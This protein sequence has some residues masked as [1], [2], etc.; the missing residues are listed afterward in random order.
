M[1]RNRFPLITNQPIGKRTNIK[2]VCQSANAWMTN[3]RQV[4]EDRGGSEELAVILPLAENPWTAVLRPS[5]SWGSYFCIISVSGLRPPGVYSVSAQGGCGAGSG[6]EMNNGSIVWAV[7]GTEK[8]NHGGAPRAL[9]LRHWYPLCHSS[10]Q[11]SGTLTM[12]L[13]GNRDKQHTIPKK[14][15]HLL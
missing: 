10:P 3:S 8:V 7:S 1:A 12:S 2:K 6:I 5:E 4:S 14:P 13:E 15:R 11:T 9:S